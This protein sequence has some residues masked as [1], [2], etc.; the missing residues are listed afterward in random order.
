MLPRTLEPE[1]LD[2]LPPD[3]PDAI[4]SRRDL[5]LINRLMRNHRWLSRTLPPLL[6]PGEIALELGAGT[7]ELGLRLAARGVPVDGLDFWPRPA[8]WPA[9]RSWHSADLCRFAGYDAYPVILGNLIFHQFSDDQLAALGAV[10]RR[11]A[12]VI[13]ACEPARQKFFQACF[14]V[15]GPVFGANAVTRHDA[16]ISIGAGFLQDELPRALGLDSQ[17]WEWHCTSTQLGAY[18]MV[19]IRRT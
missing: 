8:G 9:A 14:A 12:R 19:A 11:S 15:L 4:H 3:H 13:I 2:S 6:L 10:L 17:V 18:R 1:L 7:G 5:R 16:R